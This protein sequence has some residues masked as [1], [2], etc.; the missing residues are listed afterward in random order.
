[1]TQDDAPDGLP[2]GGAVY[3]MVTA[4]DGVHNGSV[5]GFDLQ[6]YNAV[7]GEPIASVSIDW[8]APP[9][10]LDLPSF[11]LSWGRLLPDGPHWYVRGNLAASDRGVVIRDIRIGPVE[12]E[13]WADGDEDL[14]GVPE[15]G[16]TSRVLRQVPLSVVH[17]AVRAIVASTPEED[18]GWL[19]AMMSW[20]DAHELRAA[21]QRLKAAGVG[22]GAVPRPHRDAN[23]PAL[24]REL[25]LAYIDDNEAG[26]H[27]RLGKR[28]GKSAATIRDWIHQA[29]EQGWLAPGA[30]GR[31]GALPGPLLLQEQDA[32]EHRIDQHGHFRFND[33]LREE[34]LDP[35]GHL[36]RLQTE[37]ASGGFEDRY[38]EIWFATTRIA[39]KHE[40]VARMRAWEQDFRRIHDGE[41]PFDIARGRA[42]Y[43]A[44]IT[45]I[46][47]A[48]RA[49]VL[50][51]LASK[52]Y[53]DEDILTLDRE[54]VERDQ[55]DGIEFSDYLTEVRPFAARTGEADDGQR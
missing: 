11:T 22:A 27:A 2:V 13:D 41:D 42:E 30:R 31:R 16:L 14:Q 12:D 51:A 17:G 49:D 19:H 7:S 53:Q 54:R 38:I 55:A 39:R 34:L 15:G 24:L 37:I 1:M 35:G 23:R 5:I 33:N 10:V 48:I 25:A 18:L 52:S 43:L 29:R 20:P 4:G 28:F 3:E 47:D 44:T 6:V 8:G 32:A 46:L 9:E 40:L 36:A 21:V 26:A 50:D 45:P